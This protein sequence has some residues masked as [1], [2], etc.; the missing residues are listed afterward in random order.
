MN[1]H[2]ENKEE[3][4]M[5]DFSNEL[6][7]KLKKAQSLEEITGL[8]EADG[9]DV[10]EAEKIW[11]EIEHL[12][13][14]EEKE[15]SLDELESVAGGRDW[16]A[17]G[18]AATVEPYS[19]CWGTDGGCSLHNIKY[20]NKPEDRPC[21]KCG[22]RYVAFTGYIGSCYTIAC[23]ECGRRFLMEYGEWREYVL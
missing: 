13:E 6:I 21:P 9:Q 17:K 12:Q 19:D 18:C 22:A 23:R 16:L 1:Y 15:L 10:A 3:T 5:A 4:I 14:Q 20:T 7:A 2:I 11:K 8:L